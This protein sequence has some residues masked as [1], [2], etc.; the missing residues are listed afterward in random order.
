MRKGTGQGP[1]GIK[2]ALG[3]EVVSGPWTGGRMSVL[4]FWFLFSFVIWAVSSQGND[5]HSAGVRDG[6]LKA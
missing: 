1:R 6:D 5:K 3:A 2:V 4:S